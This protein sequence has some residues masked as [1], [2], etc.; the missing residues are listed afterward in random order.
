MYIVGNVKNAHAFIWVRTRCWKSKNC[1]FWPF[2]RPLISSTKDWI[3]LISV[4]LCSALSVL[5]II[6]IKSETTHICI[7]EIFCL[8]SNGSTENY[9][10]LK[11]RFYNQQWR[12]ISALY[13]WNSTAFIWAWNT[14][15]P[16]S[17]THHKFESIE[18]HDGGIMVFAKNFFRDTRAI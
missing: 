6:N 5:T 18:G 7:I 4:S 17:C 1:H 13:Q 12:W 2:S 3:E 9:E 15:F 10:K 11:F 8:I 14:F 16:S